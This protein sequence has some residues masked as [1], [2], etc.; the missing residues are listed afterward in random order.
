MKIVADRS[1]EAHFSVSPALGYRDGNRVF[2]DTDNPR[3][4]ELQTHR[5]FQGRASESNAVPQP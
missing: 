3:Q 2:V 1:V 4:N 5:P